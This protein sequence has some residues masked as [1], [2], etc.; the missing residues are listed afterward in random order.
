[1]SICDQ[2]IFCTDPLTLCA[3]VSSRFPNSSV[4]AGGQSC[5][6][7]KPSLCWMFPESHAVYDVPVFH[8]PQ[9]RCRRS[10]GLVF[11]RWPC[12]RPAAAVTTTSWTVV[13]K[14]SLKYLPT[15]PRALWR[16]KT[17]VALRF[18]YMCKCSIDQCSVG[19]VDWSVHSTSFIPDIDAEIFWPHFPS[20]RLPAFFFFAFLHSTQHISLSNCATWK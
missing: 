1:M 11:H 12:V 7:P 2:V 10:R 17:C 14:A 15:S 13:A 16:C 18:P 8:H 4:A 20:S 9:V 3:A 5:P 6:L 19:R